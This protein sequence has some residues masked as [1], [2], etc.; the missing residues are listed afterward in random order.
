MEMNQ[1]RLERLNGCHA[2]PVM[3]IFNHYA[4]ND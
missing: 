4:E 1:Y 3:A 2:A